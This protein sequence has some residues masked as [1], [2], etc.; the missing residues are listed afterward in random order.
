[1]SLLRKIKRNQKEIQ[2]II[3][4]IDLTGTVIGYTNIPFE[5]GNQFTYDNGIEYEVTCCNEVNKKGIQIIFVRTP[6]DI[7]NMKQN[8][9]KNQLELE[10]GVLQ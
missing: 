6:Q 2:V 4:G 8:E 9:V 1:M 7:L 5:L 10:E 3:Y